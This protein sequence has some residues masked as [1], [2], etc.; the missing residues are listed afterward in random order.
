MGEPHGG[1]DKFFGTGPERELD[2]F[3]GAEQVG[4]DR[5]VVTLWVGEEQRGAVCSDD[6]TVN[7]CDLEV[8][9][10]LGFDDH[11]VFFALE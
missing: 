5:K 8:R 9:V 4:R 3:F 7:F 10:A 11:D 1:L 6:A 2:A